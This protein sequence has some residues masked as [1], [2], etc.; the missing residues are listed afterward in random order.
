VATI[1]VTKLESSGRQRK[2]GMPRIS[3]GLLLLV[4]QNIR[5]GVSAQEREKQDEREASPEGGRE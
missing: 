1:R 4:N 2:G 5:M 3:Q